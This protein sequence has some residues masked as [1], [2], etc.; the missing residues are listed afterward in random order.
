MDKQSGILIKKPISL[1][2]R[3]LRADYSKFMEACTKAFAY[4][5]VGNME[6]AI[7]EAKG[8]LSALGLRDDEC[9]QLA[10]FLIHSALLQ[11]VKDL[12]DERMT[13]L[14]PEYKETQKRKQY[15]MVSRRQTRA[16]LAWNENEALQHWIT[17]CGIKPMDKDLFKLVCD[18]M[19]LQDVEQVRQW[20]KTL[21]NLI[22]YLLK[23]G[24]PMERISPRL[25]YHA[26]TRQARNAEEALLVTLN[27]CARVTQQL[28][29]IEWP[30]HSA[31]GEWVYRIQGQSPSVD[32]VLFLDCL[33]FLDLHD[34]QLRVHHFQCANFCGA[35]LEQA[36]LEGG[37]HR[38][39]RFEKANLKNVTFEDADLMDAKFTDANLE[40][41]NL[42]N[43]YL[44]GACFERAN[45]KGATL[46]ASRFYYANLRQAHI[47]RANLK[48]ADLEGADI[49]GANFSD[50]IWTNGKKCLPNSISHPRFD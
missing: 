15:E 42:N 32:R 23:H 36:N 37:K 26:E 18:E 4:G 6:S 47:E 33:S 31:F 41:A 38:N 29:K 7:I 1:L 35:N 30:S 2:K 20:Q 25:D 50:A 8:M 43:A 3:H 28:S 13:S 9:P 19:R 46:K 10:W 11:A 44:A 21:A 17:L 39:A 14:P 5:I 45:L 40:G 48:Q 12:L 22:G 49:E 27:A 24:M 16:H 34:C